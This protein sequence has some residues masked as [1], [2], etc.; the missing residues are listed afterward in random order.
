MTKSTTALTAAAVLI[1]VVAG[2]C[3]RGG[4]LNRPESYS[5]RSFYVLAGWTGGP[6][7]TKFVEWAN[8]Y[9]ETTFLTDD[10]IDDFGGGLS[11][12]AGLSHRFARH[13]ALDFDFALHSVSTS[14]LYINHNPAIPISDQAQELDMNVAEFS[15]SLP[16]I[17]QFSPNQPL[18]PFLA[19]GI[20]AFSIRL[21]HA[22]DYNIRHTKVAL[23]AGF[24]AG[25]QIRL[26][27]RLS[28]NARG[29]W[30]AGKTTMPVS[31]IYGQPDR[32]QL[33][34]ATSQFLIGILY[35]ID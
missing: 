32:F 5:R 13:L 14:K 24:S 18:V 20:S 8:T 9:Y 35:G 25:T 16:V 15:A 23:A 12:C 28:L 1:S 33:N 6:H 22:I 31:A 26:D 7:F 17:F 27:N 30:T 3:Q 34:L 2:Y 10:R 11:F 21:D 29:R 4:Y 19:I